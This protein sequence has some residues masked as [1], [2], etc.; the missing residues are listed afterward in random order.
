MP[1]TN[2]AGNV[3][4]TPEVLQRPSTV[5]DLQQVVSRS[6]RVRALGSGHSFNR[7][8]DTS[9]VL[10]SVQG[11]PQIIEVD[12]DAATVRISAGLSYGEVGAVLQA[13]G[14][15]LPNL[16]SLPHISVAG[17]CATGTHGSGSR[18][19]NLGR[20]VRALTMVTG[21]GDLVSVGRH[22]TD[23]FDGHV[24]ALGRL[25]IVTELILDVV[26]S[27]DVAQTVLVGLPDEAV[28]GRMQEIL[29]AAYSVSIFTG[30]APGDC[31]VWLK[32]RIGDSGR[33]PADLWGARRADRAQ[34]PVPGLPGEFA[35]AQLGEPGPWNERVPHFR[36]DFT[37]SAGD[38][39]QS[40]YLLPA[41]AGPSAYQALRGLAGL[42]GPNLIIGEIRSVAGDPGWLSTTGGTDCVAFHFTWQP[43]EAAVR[44]VLD[45]IEPELLAL[46]ARP[47]WG[48]VFTTPFRV[49]PDLYPRLNDF[50][51]LV[52]RYD[53]AGVF[54]NDLVD[55]WLGLTA[56]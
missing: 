31:R 54:G 29:D 53:P 45:A 23:D 55:G 52:R 26:P 34:N 35:T 1:I 13:A 17:A 50:C 11:L 2:W 49:F 44:P 10:V 38:E 14:L 3:R 8:A 32:Q 39:L 48:K 56:G 22:S 28:S 36:L 21:G 42:I 6:G 40:E 51:G 16:G 47:H 18:H 24:L 33:V 41:A 46:G 43:D 15:A 4:F 37:P 5:A 9:G 27:Y 30:F 12:T 19:P 20:S 25:G 7:I